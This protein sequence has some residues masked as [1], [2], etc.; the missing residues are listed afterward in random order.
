[1]LRR[2][3]FALTAVALCVSF[4]VAEEFRALFLKVDVAKKTITLKKVP[5]D[6]VPGGNPNELATTTLEAAEGVRV[7]TPRK[8]VK[9][10]K[11]AADY[12]KKPA[13]LAYLKPLA[14]VGTL[15]YTSLEVVTD[16]RGKVTVIRVRGKSYF[17]KAKN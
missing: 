9:K 3:L 4:T 10:P 15:T 14:P 11:D 5:K 17:E 6:G 2:F 16:E 1:M 12:E 7:F 13:G 8:S